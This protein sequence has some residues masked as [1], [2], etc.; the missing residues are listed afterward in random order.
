MKCPRCGEEYNE[1][2]CKKCGYTPYPEDPAVEYELAN[3]KKNI[4]DE[5]EES[6]SGLPFPK[7]TITIPCYIAAIVLGIVAFTSFPFDSGVSFLMVGVICVLIAI[8]K[9][10]NIIYMALES[11]EDRLRHRK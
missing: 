9:G 10:V 11:I 3:Q 4:D 7:N 6:Y 8:G 5:Y 1:I 2:L